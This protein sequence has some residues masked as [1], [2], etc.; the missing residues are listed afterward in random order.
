M[1]KIPLFVPFCLNRQNFKLGTKKFLPFLLLFFHQMRHII[2]ETHIRTAASLILYFYTSYN[3]V[4]L[5]N[6]Y[7]FK[8][9]TP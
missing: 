9:L 2:T 1:K 4:A 7:Y 3:E 6:S 8:K 5:D